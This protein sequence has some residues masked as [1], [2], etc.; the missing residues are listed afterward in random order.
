MTRPPAVEDWEA[1][2]WDNPDSLYQ[3]EGE[4]LRPS[5]GIAKVIGFFLLLAVAAAVVG[6][7]AYGLWAM[8]QVNPPDKS[9]E[10]ATFNV[11]AADDVE[12]VANRLQAMG[13]ITNAKLFT[14]YV[15]KKGGLELN[16]GTFNLIVHDNFGEISKV[17]R[18]P[19]ALTYDRVTFPEGFTLDQISRRLV[20][21][22][23]RLDSAKFFEVAT[24]GK[25][26]SPFQP[27]NIASLEGLVFPD[28]YQVSGDQDEGAVLKQLLRQMELVG[29]REGLD[30]APQLVGMTPYQVLTV[31]SLIEKEAKFDEDRAKIASVIYAR[32]FLGMPLEIDAALYYGQSTD[33]PFNQLKA[34][35]S[36]YNVYKHKGLPP[37][38]I[39]SPGAASIKAALNPAPPPPQS[40]CPAATDRC[41]Y[42]FYV[43]KDK[44]GHHVFATTL[45]QHDENVKVARAAGVLP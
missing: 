2:E 16:P 15:E 33:T 44:E 35:E 36:P 26:R 45:A 22:V 6:G 10:T 20:S 5:R 30:K 24:N 9:G 8:N 34:L 29:N 43:L 7:G 39:A 13:I 38:P 23:P 3:F 31:A 40:E 12:S 21:K 18:T 19:P 41:A 4:R 27:D 17:L 42:L 1:D 14:Q 32:L 25:I 37:T 28:T 11:T